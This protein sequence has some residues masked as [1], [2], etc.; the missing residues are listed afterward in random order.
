MTHGR[1]M[2]DLGRLL[3]RTSSQAAAEGNAA[4]VPRGFRQVAEA[5]AQHRETLERGGVFPSGLIDRVLARLR[6][7]E[8][9]SWQFS[10][11]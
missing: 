5:L 9:V 7:E 8:P 10:L 2:K 4:P 11:L 6:G 3:Q 1:E